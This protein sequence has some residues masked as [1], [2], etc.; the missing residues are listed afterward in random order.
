VLT[1]IIVLLVVDAKP[2]QSRPYRQA[3]VLSYADLLSQLIHRSNQVGSEV[4]SMVYKGA[5]M[6]RS[7]LYL[8]VNAAYASSEQL[9]RDLG[10]LRGTAP[11]ATVQKEADMVFL[12][13][14]DCL[15]ELRAAI[16]DVLPQSA[17]VRPNVG[18]AQHSAAEAF[19]YVIS[20]DQAF[21]QLQR[22]MH[23]LSEKATLPSSTW[24]PPGTGWNAA[25]ASSFIQ[26]L[27]GSPSL[28]PIHEVVLA[29]VSIT[30]PAESY[31][32]TASVLPPTKRLD[33]SVLVDNEGN[34]SEQG[35][36]VKASLVPQ[37]G[38]ATA[39]TST[40]RINLAAGQRREVILPPLRTVEGVTYRL[41]VSVTPVPGQT[42]PTGTSTSYVIQ[43]AP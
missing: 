8:T 12:D 6:N 43:I 28:A 7:S 15:R 38:K 21:A 41:N 19:S 18:G 22:M 17:S 37:S 24:E 9:D 33:V 10:M 31:S 11:S 29:S 16:L 42:S 36:T 25:Y 35:V 23:A 20:S 40:K 4:R 27:A 26:S 2:S 5:T 14:V 39:N 13:R 32:G 34:L 1:L 3:V 30:P